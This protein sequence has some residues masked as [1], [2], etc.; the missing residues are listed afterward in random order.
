MCQ[1]T[2]SERYIGDTVLFP[3]W[4]RQDGRVETGSTGPS[5]SMN[6][7]SNRSSEVFCFNVV[8][9]TFHNS[10]VCRSFRNRYKL[11]LVALA[12]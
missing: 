4:I 2:I 5:E 9:S 8:A 12:M 6:L 11:F 3:Y 7:R 10:K 1:S